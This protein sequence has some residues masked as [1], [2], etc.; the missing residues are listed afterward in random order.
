MSAPAGRSGSSLIIPL[1]AHLSPDL[2]PP[3]AASLELQEQVTGVLASHRGIPLTVAANPVTME[4]LL[5]DAK[6]GRRT[7]DQ[8]ESL[9]AGPG[10]DELIDQ[11]YVPVDVAA[12]A[13]GGLLGEIPATAH[14]VATRSCAKPASIPLRARGSTRPRPSRMPAPPTSGWGCRRRRRDHVVLADTNLAPVGSSSVTGRIPSRSPRP[15]PSPS[16]T[17]PTSP[18]PPPTASS[19]HFSGPTRTIR[20]WPPTNSWPPSNS[21]ISKTRSKRMPAASSSS[22]RVPGCR[23]R[24]RSSRRSSTACPATRH[25]SP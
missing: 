1:A 6:T 12:L 22:R 4:S 25:S 7:K 20:S 21:S 3:S 15:S 8:L 10:G 17:G 23:P 11:P 13:G 5:A 24:R 19:P 16:V 18:L 2:S 9:T 14:H